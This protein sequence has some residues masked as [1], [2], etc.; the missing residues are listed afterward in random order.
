MVSVSIIRSDTLPNCC[1]VCGSAAARKLRLKFAPKEEISLVSILLIPRVIRRLRRI[2]PTI[3]WSLPF[4]ETHARSAAICQRLQLPLILLS[5]GVL[6]AGGWS[7]MATHLTWPFIASVFVGG[8][9]IVLAQPLSVRTTRVTPNTLECIV[10]E[11][12]ATAYDKLNQA[13]P[14]EMSNNVAFFPFGQKA[15]DEPPEFPTFQ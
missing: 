6:V 4:C 12:F 1:I 2:I 8:V 7:L 11:G 14:L 5:L 10:D 15:S 13:R 9:S 3:A